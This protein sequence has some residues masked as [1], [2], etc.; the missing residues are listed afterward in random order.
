MG[1]YE[2]FDGQDGCFPL[3]RS[4]PT[5]A[6][7]FN[8][9]VSPAA[10]SELGGPALA[11]IVGVGAILIAT[12]RASAADELP[13][14]PILQQIDRWIAH[15]PKYKSTPRYLLL[16]FGPTAATKVWLVE[17]GKTLYVDKNADGDLADD[18]PPLK[19]TNMRELDLV[20]HGH[21]W[22]FEYKLDKMTTANGPIQSDFCLTRW[23]YGDK[24][25]QYGMSI[26]VN[27]RTP[28]YAGWSLHWANSPNEA[29]IIHFGGK[30]QPRLL[31]LKQFTLGKKP[32]EIGICFFTPGL[33]PDS[34]ARLS[35]EAIPRG[36]TPTL[37]IQW[38]TAP[39]VAAIHTTQFLDQRCCDWHYY[40]LVPRMPKSRSPEPR[41]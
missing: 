33:G 15:E 38:P 8:E 35:I 3:G 34:E 4:E 2:T 1:R 19:P 10:R 24:E 16:A 18:G 23:N 37:D 39:G 26:K 41:L 9:S 27:D 25:D 14:S 32:D 17:D 21:S 12:P 30:L 31:G 11:A 28:M 7:S 29:S 20:E 5:A 13:P 36:A 22:D 40:D 6:E